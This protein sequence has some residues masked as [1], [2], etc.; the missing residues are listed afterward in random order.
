MGALALDMPHSAVFGSEIGSLGALFEP[1]SLPEPI[2]R[3]EER[4]VVDLGKQIDRQLLAAIDSRTKAEFISVRKRV[5]PRYVRALRALSDTV[6]N[7]VPEFVLDE[8]SI[9]GFASLAE[10]IERSK[11]ARFGENLTEQALFTLWTIGKMR[12]IA[13]QLSEEILPADKHAEDAALAAEYNINALWAQFHLDAVIAALKFDKTIAAAVQHEL[14]DGLRSAVNAFTIMQD[15]LALRRVEIIGETVEDLPW[16]E[17][18]EE[19]L[20]SSMK[21]IHLGA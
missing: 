9:R 3:S 2:A 13:R 8:V 16:D 12:P 20:A 15:G 21:D 18:D 7:L 4:L 19:L 5:W 6:S 10:D 1:S 14:C 17:E 11:D